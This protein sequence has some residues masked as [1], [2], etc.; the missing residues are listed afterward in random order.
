[1]AAITPKNGR[2]AFI[3][4]QDPHTYWELNSTNLGTNYG[5]DAT[6]SG[7]DNPAVSSGDISTSDSYEGM[8]NQNDPTTSGDFD[9][10]IV[11]DACAL[12]YIPAGLTH[13]YVYGLW[14]NGGNTNAQGAYL[15]ATTTGVE[16]AISVSI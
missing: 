8:N 13:D 11:T 6:A 16:I 5:H 10:W 12:V 4:A 7:G 2:V 3:T 15:R 9:R 1:M 14:H